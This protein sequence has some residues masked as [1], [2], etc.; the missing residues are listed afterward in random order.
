MKKI[1]LI[2]LVVLVFTFS[3][4]KENVKE[5]NFENNTIANKMPTGSSSSD[6]LSDDTFT[7]MVIELVYVENYKPT[8][9]AINN[10]SWRRREIIQRSD[11]AFPSID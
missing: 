3:C 2:G 1:A 6:L 7:S 5:D 4:T 11:L 8:Q 10:F 9:I